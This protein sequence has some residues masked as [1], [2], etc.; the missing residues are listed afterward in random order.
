MPRP[1]FSTAVKTALVILLAAVTAVEAQTD[2]TPSGAFR[3]SLGVAAYVSGTS[4]DSLLP[5]SGLPSGRATLQ[6]QLT[7]LFGLQ[8]GAVRLAP[9]DSRLTAGVFGIRTNLLQGRFRVA[10][11]VEAGAGPSEAIL[12]DQGYWTVDGDGN[13]VFRSVPQRVEGLAYGG[14][15]GMDVQLIVGPGLT[16]ELSGG[17][18]HFLAPEHTVSGVFG[19][20]GLRLAFRDSPWYWRTSGRDGVGPVIRLLA[21]ADSTGVIQAPQTGLELVLRDLSGVDVAYVNRETVGLEDAPP[22]AADGPGETRLVRIAGLEPGVHD[23]QLSVRDGAGNWVRENLRVRQPEPD[24]QGPYI[25]VLQPSPGTAVSRDRVTLVGSV[26]DESSIAEIRVGDRTARVEP[27]TRGIAAGAGQGAAAAG[28]DR[29]E[30]SEAG[31]SPAGQRF[32]VDVDLEPGQNQI[33]V[34]ARDVRGNESMLEY[35]IFRRTGIAQAADDAEGPQIQIMEPTEWQ[36]AGARGIAVAARQSVKVVGSARHLAGVREVRINGQVVAVQA[37]DPSRQD[38]TFTGYVPVDPGTREV[39]IAAWAADGRYS[40]R[41]F[42]IQPQA[43]AGADD[44]ATGVWRGER[45]GVIIGISEYQDPDIPQL[46]YADDDAEAFYEFLTSEEAGLGG[47]PEENLRLLVNEE[48]T[49]RNMRSAMNTFLEQATDEDIVYVFIAGHG[50]PNP[51]RLDELYVLPYDTD[52]DDLPGSAYPM[53][54][55]NEAISRLYAQ[56]TVLI[57][58]ACHSGG[59]GFG[60]L[61]Y[62]AA[63]DDG[64]YNLI[65]EAFLQDLQSTRSG[66]AIFTASEA[67]QLSREGE[68]WGGGHGVF[69]HFLLEG[70][71]GDADVDGDRIVRLGEVMEYVRDR[72]RRATNNAQIPSIGS[73]SHDRYLPMSVVGGSSNR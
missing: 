39:E 66:L 64:T 46:Q 38:V 48:A 71:R 54:H 7:P 10:P 1:R 30:R 3:T 45:F 9:S 17:Y 27:R 4:P 25:A 47:I 69:T 32:T 29:P 49:Y 20:A 31:P 2:P 68:E 23:I 16:L 59:V 11:F 65:N 24:N 44:L 22:E 72:V 41:V 62:R 40:A 5:A 12:R 35:G 33:T 60:E 37:D 51:N 19:G 15:A 8:A 52:A 70:L 50:A 67:S 58:D 42:R 55:V 34:V 56:H 18:F 63:G 43:A 26:S 13:R 28:G 61:A 6:F 53:E 57:T 36:G 73:Q 21:E 14:G